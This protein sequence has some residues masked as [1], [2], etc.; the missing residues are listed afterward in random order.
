MS[1]LQRRNFNRSFLRVELAPNQP[2]F[3]CL[4]VDSLGKK[5]LDKN[6]LRPP[7]APGKSYEVRRVGQ[8]FEYRSP[9]QPAARRSGLL[10]SPT[11]KFKLPPTYSAG[12]PPPPI[13]L[14]INPARQPGNVAGSLQR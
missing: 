2:A 7:A 3:T 1:L 14:D 5:K 10:N 12:N 11:G 8:R 9:G 6:P 13:L 4:T